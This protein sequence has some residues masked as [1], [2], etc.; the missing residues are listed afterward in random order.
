MKS[1]RRSLPTPH[2]CWSGRNRRLLASSDMFRQRLLAMPGSRI[3][4]YGAVA[5]NVGIAVTKFIAAGL[6]GS[7]A[8]FAEAIHSTV[9][10]G[11][12]LLLLVG[13]KRSAQKADAEHPFGYGKA[14]YFWSL[15]VAMLIFGVGGVV[16]I[17]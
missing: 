1:S 10:T 11:N 5:A 7:S 4:V 16:S 9:D 12:G 8:M 14:L 13:M 17:F 6:S 3:A 15:V 2:P